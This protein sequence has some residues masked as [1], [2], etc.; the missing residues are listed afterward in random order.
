MMIRASARPERTGLVGPDRA[1]TTERSQAA[2]TPTSLEGPC[3]KAISCLRNETC[4][5]PFVA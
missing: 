4:A 1:E 3:R 2:N 5:A